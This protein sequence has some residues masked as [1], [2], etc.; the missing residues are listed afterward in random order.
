[1]KTT[2]FNL[3]V[4]DRPT[5]HGAGRAAGRQA[6][7]A[8]DFTGALDGKAPP[9]KPVPAS[10]PPLDTAVP[11]S[12]SDAAA[13][14]TDLPKSPRPSF[15]FDPDLRDRLAVSSRQPAS[16]RTL[17]AAPGEPDM[18]PRPD[19]IA[20]DDA[21]DAPVS[22]EFPDADADVASPRTRGL[23]AASAPSRKDT[24]PVVPK[25][26]QK[27]G[28]DRA[29]AAP[30]AI[31]PAPSPV[32]IRPVAV[33][34][35][36]RDAGDG[37]TGSGAVIAAP[38]SRPPDGEDPPGDDAR[39]DGRLQA[40]AEARQGNT[41]DHQGPAAPAAVVAPQAPAEPARTA[42]GQPAAAG[43]SPAAR[44]PSAPPPA[45]A[46][47]ARTATTGFAAQITIAAARYS[48]AA[49][50]GSKAE[51][52]P[53]TRLS[54]RSAAILLD[55]AEARQRPVSQAIAAATDADRTGKEPLPAPSS[56]PGPASHSD[57]AP[58]TQ[59][60]DGDAERG[61]RAV[62]KAETSV[63]Q[64]TQS[65]PQAAMPA[66]TGTGVS[67]TPAAQVTE[68][69]ANAPAWQPATVAAM[70][71]ARTYRAMAAAAT[72]ELRLAPEH[73][74]GV[75][76]SLRMSGTQLEIEIRV[77]TREAM[78][79][80]Q[81]EKHV[82]ETTLR[83]LGYDIAQVSISQS[84]IAQQT[85]ARGADAQQQPTLAHSGGGAQAQANTSSEGNSSNGRQ[86]D[87]NDDAARSANQ[88]TTRPVG[89]DRGG[90]YI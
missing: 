8:A 90:V 19:T 16:P 81:A 1:M 49:E 58:G 65:V 62:A 85:A 54:E 42:P 45:S 35:P 38:V 77:E 37:S 46:E 68:L 50:T 7:E 5:Q 83:T 30:P 73:L 2:A 57:A 47:P 41:R 28:Q 43:V 9:A 17:P 72:L 24:A 32:E 22:P 82:M 55:E 18:A 51:A 36:A 63:P 64:A 67:P 3:I 70:T 40:G 11:E 69:I 84:P 31:L 59:K 71:Q 74:G 44:A 76:A 34:Q 27:D 53:A 21:G 33:R 13:P 75:N 15:A 10:Q 87:R 20:G 80:L 52:R 88:Q 4:A 25:A 60:A 26:E 14:A 39:P 12:M 6:R 89:G 23:P 48:V 61:A 86:A 56:R 29:D 66:A 79:R 78:E